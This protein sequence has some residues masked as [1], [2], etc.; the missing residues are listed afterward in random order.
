MSGGE[1]STNVSPALDFAA[2][3][4]IFKPNGFADYNQNPVTLA[5]LT[6]GWESPTSR[7]K[8]SESQPTRFGIV[9]LMVQATS[10]GQSHD[11]NV[12]PVAFQISKNVSDDNWPWPNSG[13]LS[14]SQLEDARLSPHEDAMVS[15]NYVISFPS[16]L[17]MA[18]ADISSCLTS[19]TV[20]TADGTR[21]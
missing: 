7:C 5:N 9:K 16:M 14:S 18:M 20:L 2:R 12:V 1:M 4:S 15:C 21:E 10:K 6:Y 8:R 19:L 13:S 17:G 11:F 3:Q